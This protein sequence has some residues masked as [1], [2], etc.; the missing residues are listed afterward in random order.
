MP[1]VICGEGSFDAVLSLA[2]DIEARPGIIDKH[3]NVL[4]VATNYPRQLMNFLS[5]GQISLDKANVNARRCLPNKSRNLGATPR[6]TADKNE[7]RVVSR[8]GEGGGAPNT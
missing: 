2:I 3:I 8:Q 7:V 4:E 5:P 6:A 1:E